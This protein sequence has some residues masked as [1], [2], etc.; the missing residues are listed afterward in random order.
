MAMGTAGDFAGAAD[1]YG[2]VLE[3]EPEN[4]EAAR[5][6]GFALFRLGLMEES[7]ASFRKAEALTPDNPVLLEQLGRFFSAQKDY[8]RAAEYFQRA[9]RPD[10]TGDGACP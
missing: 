10:A 2:K 6:R 9:A 1:A 4:A 5:K 7:L 3:I 8:D